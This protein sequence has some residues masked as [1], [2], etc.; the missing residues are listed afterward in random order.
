MTL[1]DVLEKWKKFV[2][3]MNEKGVPLPMAR[4]PKT[5]MGS[6][7][8]SL[9]VFSAGLCGLAI[10]F[11][12]AGALAKLTGFLVLNADTIAQIKAA[13]DSGFQFLIASLSAYLGRKF[14]KDSKGDITVESDPQKDPP[15]QA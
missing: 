12:L 9:V 8:L 11:M 13:F 15:P 3:D 2:S 1:N 6:V 7:T 14:Q 10:L 4:D 5:K